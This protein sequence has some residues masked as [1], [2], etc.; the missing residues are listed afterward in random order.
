MPMHENKLATESNSWGNTKDTANAK[1][2]QDSS[3]KQTTPISI[4]KATTSDR[5]NISYYPYL[6][7]HVFTKVNYEAPVPTDNVWIGASHIFLPKFWC[8][9]CDSWSSHHEKL[10]D[11]HTRWKA[12]NTAQLA[13]QEEYRKQNPQ[14]HYGPPYQQNRTFNRNY[15]N[16]R[17][18]NSYNHEHNQDKRSR[19]DHGRSP[20]QDCSNSQTRSPGDNHRNGAS[21]YDDKKRN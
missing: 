12:M 19:T 5:S 7:T 10:H 18:D 13:K 21:F 6:S 16:K 11:E 15:N 14:N 4:S 20:S 3:T 8:S 17:S 1:Q 2:W 9:K